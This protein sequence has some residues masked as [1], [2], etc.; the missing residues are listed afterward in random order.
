[1]SQDPY[2]EMSGDL[3]TGLQIHLKTNLFSRD[4]ALYKKRKVT[5]T[6]N[7]AMTM[8]NGHD[9]QLVHCEKRCNI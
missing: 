8:V 3:K 4:F 6:D 1:M 5:K 9:C 7:M 2:E